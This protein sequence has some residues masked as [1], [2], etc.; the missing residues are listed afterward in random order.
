MNIQASFFF[1]FFFSVHVFHS[2][3]GVLVYFPYFQK[4]T[5]MG[6]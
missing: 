1:F 2:H 6:I 3:K 4:L 5:V